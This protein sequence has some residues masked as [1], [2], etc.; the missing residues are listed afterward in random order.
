MRVVGDYFLFWKEKPYTNFTKCKIVGPDG[1][2]FASSE[3]MFMW[4]KARFFGDFETAE[5][6]VTAKTCEEARQLGRQVRNYIDWK[7]DP[8]RYNVMHFCV[9]EK[10]RQNPEFLANLA[11]IRNKGLWFAEAAYYDRIWGIGFDEEHA[12]DHMK[13]WGKNALGLILDTVA[14][15]LAEGRENE[16]SVV[17]ERLE[18]EKAFK[19]AT[20]VK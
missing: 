2:E 10:F 12:E 8:V 7:W 6:I 16:P 3:H 1:T 19:D 11:E 13:E 9:Y 20:Y 15:S 5:K 17:K 18:L 14:Y 4:A